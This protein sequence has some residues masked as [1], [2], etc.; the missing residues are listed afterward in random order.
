MRVNW[1]SARHLWQKDW[2]LNFHHSD[3]ERL[4]ALTLDFNLIWLRSSDL[5]FFN[6]LSLTEESSRNAIHAVSIRIFLRDIFWILFHFVCRFFIAIYSLDI[7]F[8]FFGDLR[9]KGLD[10]IFAL[11]IF[12]C[13]TLVTLSLR[14]RL[15]TD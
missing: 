15:V 9:H 10:Q 5:F 1:G 3:L 4:A 13:F 8:Q 6:R 2:L 7:L 14:T 12:L 11:I